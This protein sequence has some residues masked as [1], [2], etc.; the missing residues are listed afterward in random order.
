MLSDKEFKAQVWKMID[1]KVPVGIIVD[2]FQIERPEGYRG[3]II[4]YANSPMFTQILAEFERRDY[5]GM[6]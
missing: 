2:F 3:H 5:K 4:I 1:E 6:L